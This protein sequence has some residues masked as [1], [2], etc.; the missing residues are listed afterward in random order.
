MKRAAELLVAF[1]LATGAAPPAS[2]LK[3]IHVVIH[4]VRAGETAAGI[5]KKYGTT[6]STLETLNPGLDLEGLKG[7]ERLRILS[8][9]GVFQKVQPGLTVSDIALVYEINRDELLKINDITNPRKIRAGSELFIPDRGPLPA[10]KRN[11]LAKQVKERNYRVPRGLFGNPLE[12]GR[13]LVASDQFGDRRHPITR[14]LQK[15]TGIDLVAPWGT[16]IVAARAGTVKF[17]GRNGGYGIM[18][19]LEHDLGYETYYAHA[20]D[21]SVRA[22]EQV[23]ESQVIGRVGATGDV[24]APHLHFEIRRYGSPRNPARYL[25]RYF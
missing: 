22:G 18:V 3:G 24:T 20:T 8:R 16:P 10:R 2:P 11:W 6:K 25:Q 21:I 14:K 1:T 17:A 15:H 9:P 7:G 4:E 23:A 12:I 13:R 5:L 19:I